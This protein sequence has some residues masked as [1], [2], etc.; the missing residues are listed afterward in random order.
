MSTEDLTYIQETIKA[1]SKDKFKYGVA[2][3][4]VIVWSLFNWDLI[5]FMLFDNSTAEL[6]IQCIK[7]QYLNYGYGCTLWYF[8]RNI[9]IAAFLT[10]I[11]PAVQIGLNYLSRGIY[12][13]DAETEEI[14]LGAKLF[15]ENKQLKSDLAEKIIIEKEFDDAKEGIQRTTDSLN[16]KINEVEEYKK[17]IDSENEKLKKEL[18]EL[19][20]EKIQKK[21]EEFRK[22]N[23]IPPTGDAPKK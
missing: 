8:L 19:K 1:A 23:H 5:Y 2:I 20:E 21:L 16:A 6:K 18:D 22:N 17:K 11:F 9:S 7:E 10:F 14:K 3:T 15:E 13:I 12:Q 4:Y